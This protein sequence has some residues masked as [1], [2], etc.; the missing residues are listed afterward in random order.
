MGLIGKVITVS[1]KTVGIMERLPDLGVG[2][3]EEG[4]A[5]PGSTEVTREPSD[6]R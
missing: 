5:Q 6:W 1:L 4:G 3:E 2:E